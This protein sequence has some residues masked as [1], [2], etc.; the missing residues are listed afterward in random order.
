MNI[1]RYPI[2]KAKGLISLRKQGA[3]FAAEMATF[4]A[5]TGERGAPLVEAL[6]LAGISSIYE[7]LRTSAMAAKLLLDDL[8]ALP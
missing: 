6:D 8:K 3:A 1:N 4:D 2:L 7:H 5:D